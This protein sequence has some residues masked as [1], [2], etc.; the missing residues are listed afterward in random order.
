MAQYDHVAIIFNPGSSGDAPSMAKELARTIDSEQSRIGSKAFLMPTKRAGHAV[1]LARDVASAHEFPLIIS[2]SGDGGYNEVV[3]GAMRAKRDDPEANPVVAVAA[4]GN[5]NDHR[6]VMRDKPLIELITHA[7]PRPLDLLLTS[8]SA[9][10]F[11]LERY[12]HSYMGLGVTPQVGHELNKHGKSLLYELRTILKT[13]QSYAPFTI[14]RD[15]TDLELDNLIFANIN[16]MAKVLKLDDTNNVHD[17]KFEVIA[18][19]HRSRLGMLGTLL[20]A[21]VLGFSDRPSYQNYEFRTHEAL[22][23]QS[24]GEVDRLPVNSSVTVT[25]VKQ[26]ILSLYDA[27]A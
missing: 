10:G 18:L 7:E 9:D 25:S 8:V 24:D 19:R 21:A 5:A 4:A 1:E 17:G 23:M 12:A 22:P 14:T 27:D 2:V 26:A 13:Y 11:S 6:R 20:R 15:G 16:E 3:N